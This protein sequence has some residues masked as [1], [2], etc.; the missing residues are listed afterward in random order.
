MSCALAFSINEIMVNQSDFGK[1][2]TIELQNYDNIVVISPYSPPI[3]NVH[4]L[5]STFAHR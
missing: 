3:Q 2:C 4:S 5:E 1:I